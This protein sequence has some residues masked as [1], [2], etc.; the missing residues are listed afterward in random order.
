MDKILTDHVSMT[1]LGCNDA[2]KI[3]PDIPHHLR[4]HHIRLN[5][6]GLKGQ[7]GCAPRNYHVCSGTNGESE[8][9]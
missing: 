3:A 6:N 8:E 2:Q 5:V 4:R 9:R 1:A 7:V